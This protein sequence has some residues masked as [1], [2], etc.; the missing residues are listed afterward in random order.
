M[1]CIQPRI[2]EAGRKT[3]WIS[4]AGA[5]LLVSARG[6][7]VEEWL[8]S[9]LASPVAVQEDGKILVNIGT[10]DL[11]R[12]LPD[13]R[14]DPT[15]NTKFA[16]ADKVQGLAIGDDGALIAQG[17]FRLTGSFTSVGLVLL[18]PNGNFQA[19]F[20]DTQPMG[21]SLSAAARPWIQADGKILMLKDIF[22]VQDRNLLRLQPN[23]SRDVSFNS[24]VTNVG[25][26]APLADGKILV[27]N[28]GENG[29]LYRL[30][31][32]GSVDTAFNS[33]VYRVSGFAVQADGTIL[34]VA[35]L[36]G[37]T[38]NGWSGRALAR[39]GTTGLLDATFDPGINT[40]GA[41]E[42]VL[43]QADGKIVVKG[44]F[45]MLGGIAC[46]NFGRLNPDGTLDRALSTRYDTIDYLVPQEDGR[47]LLRGGIRIPTEKPDVFRT[48]SYIARLGGLGAATENLALNG[49]TI[50]WMRGGTS[51]EVWRTMFS[52]STNGNDWIELGPGQRIAGG[53]QLTGV[54]VPANATIRARG[55]LASGYYY[56]SLVGAPVIKP[57]GT[58]YK[59]ESGKLRFQV[60]GPSGRTVVI[61][62]SEDLN[63]WDEVCTSQ[64]NEG[65][66][67]V[68]TPESTDASSR[69]YRARLQ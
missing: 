6:Q 59:F 15:F 39:V 56:D 38:V 29:R 11:D 17:S 10:Y 27:S 37:V 43:V 28:S 66:L 2:M 23:G 4:L 25:Q 68:T 41:V 69:F 51:P 8:M 62:A 19:G 49:N 24:A 53:W 34:A 50:T 36:H 9:S 61:E 57:S 64:T 58:S 60:C 55:Y 44:R 40:N 65:D 46:T 32:D 45:T 67:E 7:T 54:S 30:L 18:S 20:V 3:F 47:I 35:G 13:G 26:A 33:D 14:K 1:K 48:E 12:L 31:P 5:M 52:S 22:M 16:I 42:E 63:H 21:P